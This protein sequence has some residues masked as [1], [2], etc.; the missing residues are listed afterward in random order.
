M[1]ETWKTY[2][3]WQWAL[4]I[5]AVGLIA[6]AQVPAE[7]MRGVGNPADPWDE[8]SPTCLSAADL[9]PQAMESHPI[10]AM[11][12][13]RVQ[14]VG[15]ATMASLDPQTGMRT[16]EVMVAMSNGNSVPAVF[17]AYFRPDGQEVVELIRDKK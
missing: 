3:R 14:A 10:Y 11:F 5:V 7:M 1:A 2:P 16:C 12:N 17:R 6:A 13:A 15:P 8:R 4:A 9:L